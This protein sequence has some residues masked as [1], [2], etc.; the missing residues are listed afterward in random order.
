VRRIAVKRHGRHVVNI[1]VVP[2][3]AFDRTL[4]PRLRWLLQAK[5]LEDKWTTLAE[6]LVE[7]ASYPSDN[8]SGPAMSS[9]TV[10]HRSAAGTMGWIKPCGRLRSALLR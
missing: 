10:C 4:G 8:G 6:L 1:L 2:R 9:A 3:V 5:L 7:L